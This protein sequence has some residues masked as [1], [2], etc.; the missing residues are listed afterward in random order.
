MWVGAGA[1]YRGVTPDFVTLFNPTKTFQQ[2]T[3]DLVANLEDDN[4]R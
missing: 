3:E 4:A 2:K 1:S